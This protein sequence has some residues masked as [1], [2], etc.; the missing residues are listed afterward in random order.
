MLTYISISFYIR[1]CWWLLTAFLFIFCGLSSTQSQAEELTSL[2]QLQLIKTNPVSIIT[3][4]YKLLSNAYSEPSRMTVTWNTFLEKPNNMPIRGVYSTHQCPGMVI[5]REVR[6]GYIQ[7]PRLQRLFPIHSNLDINGKCLSYHDIVSDTALS[8]YRVMQMDKKLI[9]LIFLQDDRFLEE[10]NY[11]NEI[12]LSIKHAAPDLLIPKIY[13]L[14]NEFY[15]LPTKRILIDPAVSLSRNLLRAGVIYDRPTNDIEAILVQL[16]LANQEVEI[17]TET[18]DDG[19]KLERI[20]FSKDRMV[21]LIVPNLNF[22]NITYPFRL[23]LNGKRSLKQ[24]IARRKL[25]RF[26][27]PDRDEFLDLKDNSKFL[28]NLK[29]FNPNIANKEDMLSNKYGNVV[30]PVQSVSIPF[31][32]KLLERAQSEDK[33]RER[34]VEVFVNPITSRPT[35]FVDVRP[36]ANS[37]HLGAAAPRQPISETKANAWCED[38]NQKD[39]I[40]HLKSIGLGPEREGNGATLFVMDNFKLDDGWIG[41]KTTKLSKIRELALAMEL[42]KITH[43]Y[44]NLT[45]E[46][47]IEKK[48]IDAR[49]E[50]SVKMKEIEEKYP[51]EKNE[52]LNKAKDITDG[53]LSLE[54]I[55]P[56]PHPD[57][58]NHFEFVT[59]PQSNVYSIENKGKLKADGHHGYH[60]AS[61]AGARCNGEG[62]AGVLQDLK[63][64]PYNIEM[65][66]Q[67]IYAQ[68]KKPPKASDVL[69]EITDLSEHEGKTCVVNMSFSSEF[70]AVKGVGENLFENLS[71]FRDK[72]LAIV[73]AGDKE[74][75]ICV[76][77]GGRN[78]I[79]ACYGFL[80]N[81]LTVTAGYVP[82]GE[83]DN[84][85]RARDTSSG[86]WVLLAAP[87]V[88]IPAAGSNCIMEGTGASQATAFVSAVAA[89]IANASESYSPAVIVERLLY[90]ADLTRGIKGNDGKFGWLN[91]RRAW[92]NLNYDEYNGGIG[93]IKVLK[94]K[95]SEHIRLFKKTSSKWNSLRQADY[96]IS[97]HQIL[98][99]RRDDRKRTDPFNYVVVYR[100]KFNP[101]EKEKWGKMVADYAPQCTLQ[102]L[103]DVNF[104]PPKD[105]G[106]QLEGEGSIFSGYLSSFFTFRSK[107]SSDEPIPISLT[108][109]SDLTRRMLPPRRG[110]CW[111][112]RSGSIF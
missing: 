84:R 29:K 5:Q 90:T 67:K 32:K 80:P 81:V 35:V 23:K 59:M 44:R 50:V 11:E 83:P 27:Q 106:N 10:F 92:S 111:L 89:K 40:P 30:V 72:I 93:S 25:V 16:N 87:G 13:K 64:V 51:L 34:F 94:G 98:R 18:R 63:I 103:R 33:L 6:V 69:N 42:E 3:K 45:K 62:I 7:K 77:V 58:S 65:E 41:E 112:A 38:R 71:A 100:D 60:V 108:D 36:K 17:R 19:T 57:I 15:Y 22:E 75:E 43:K 96:Y 68:L 14:L 31:P 101:G 109:I 56:E 54:D 66:G 28:D 8:S 12:K 110:K 73:S 70:K 95:R 53:L 37:S 21:S 105:S 88:N 1:I 49:N 46:S 76:P 82:P 24:E 86:P 9:E 91:A 74:E 79:P 2:T 4:K 39:F 99:I 48:Y 104:L 52:M 107:D 47:K 85:L 78:M 20:V 61:I 26:Y 55:V 102:V 97:P